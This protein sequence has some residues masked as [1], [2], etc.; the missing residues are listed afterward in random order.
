MAEHWRA[1]SLT[2]DGE[3]GCAL[4]E[5]QEEYNRVRRFIRRRTKRCCARSAMI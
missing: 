4:I 2:L 3:R 5:E 1:C